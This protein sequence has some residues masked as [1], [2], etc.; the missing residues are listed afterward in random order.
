MVVS[1][2]GATVRFS[3][4]ILGHSSEDSGRNEM[5]LAC[6]SKEPE[7]YFDRYQAH[8]AACGPSVLRPSVTDLFSCNYQT[9]D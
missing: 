4:W 7:G 2:G 6:S 3:P 5:S 9:R 8:S 1:A